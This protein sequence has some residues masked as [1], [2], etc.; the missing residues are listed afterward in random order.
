MDV[1][2]MTFEQGVSALRE[3]GLPSLILFFIGYAGWRW[4]WYLLTEVVKPLA[5][6]V[7][8]FFDKLEE[9]VDS[10]VGF[11]TRIDVTMQGHGAKIDTL[12]QKHDSHGQK[13]DEQGKKIDELLSNRNNRSA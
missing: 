9:Q 5:V 7:M 3:F 11:T 6:R 1:R 4:G 8:A 10:L 12:A 13:I 2:T